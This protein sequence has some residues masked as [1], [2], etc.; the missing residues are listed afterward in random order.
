VHAFK[1]IVWT[2]V[3]FALS[4]AP[5]L[6]SETASVRH[7]AS[8]G[9]LSD[10]TEA[11]RYHPAKAFD[12]DLS[13]AWALTKAESRKHVLKININSYV[14][15]DSVQLAPG[16]FHE[17]WWEANHRIKKARITFTAN[18]MKPIVIDAHFEDTMELQEVQLPETA[19][20]SSIEIEVLELYPGSRFDDICIAEVVPLREGQPITFVPPT[21][22]QFERM[23]AEWY[24]A[25]T[26][27]RMRGYTAEAGTICKTTVHTTVMDRSKGFGRL[28]DLAREIVRADYPLYGAPKN[29]DIALRPVDAQLT[30]EYYT[31]SKS[32][33]A[34][35]SVIVVKPHDI[36][37]RSYYSSRD[38]RDTSLISGEQYDPQTIRPNF[39]ELKRILREGPVALLEKYRSDDYFI[40]RH[41]EGNWY[42]YRRFPA[43][44]SH[45]P[46]NGELE[47]WVLEAL[48]TPEDVRGKYGFMQLERGY[49]EIH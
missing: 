2:L 29:A 14:T 3:L 26:Y 42:I 22:K 10:S 17:R 8:S 36:V 4:S 49:R 1:R 16:Y 38:I 45:T 44:S 37:E 48:V 35:V 43:S 25:H 19:E 46:E 40:T 31:F 30:S 28:R 9:F 11:Y 5:Q 39:E 13:T 34:P 15:A 33:T 47:Y 20:I 6:F 18:G 32:S 41:N 23:Y 27:R 12:G 21:P 7:Y 24:T